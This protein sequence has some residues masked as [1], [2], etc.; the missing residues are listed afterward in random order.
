ME[1]QKNYFGYTVFASGKIIGKQ[2]KTLKENHHNLGYRSVSIYRNG[3]SKRE[4]V[5]RIVASLF[6]V[7][8]KDKNQVN[9]INGDKSDNRVENLEWVTAKENIKHARE[10]ALIVTKKGKEHVLSKKIKAFYPDGTTK[11]FYGTRDVEVK[12]GVKRKY[13]CRVLNK[14]RNHHCGVVYQHCF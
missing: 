10:N 5:H 3:N 12:T 13:V 9:H 6:L 14:K 8:E 11:I 2:G 7:R 1:K 4:Y